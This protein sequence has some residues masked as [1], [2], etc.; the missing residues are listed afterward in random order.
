M[1]SNNIPS[2]N[3]YLEIVKID[4]ESQTL[5]FTDFTYY[6]IINTDIIDHGF[7]KYTYDAHGNKILYDIDFRKIEEVFKD[8]K[9]TELQIP[10]DVT[11]VSLHINIKEHLRHFLSKKIKKLSFIGRMFLKNP[12]PLTICENAFNSL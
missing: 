3:I 4:D 5:P 9:Y 10:S 1:L 8:N 7:L 12:K 11:Q 2:F 6:P